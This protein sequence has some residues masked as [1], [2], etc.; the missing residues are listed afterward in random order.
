LVITDREGNLKNVYRLNPKI[1]KKPEGITFTPTGDMI[2]SNEVFLEDYS[3][4][5]ILKNKKKAK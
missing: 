4:L 3:T 1:Y 2:I 5:L